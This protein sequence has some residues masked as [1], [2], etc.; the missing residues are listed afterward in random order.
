MIKQLKD[1]VSDELT[2]E[3]LSPKSIFLAV[4]LWRVGGGEIQVR[5]E[6]DLSVKNIEHAWLSLDGHQVDIDGSY[7]PIIELDTDDDS[8]VLGLTEST[9]LQL[10]RT[11]VEISDDEWEQEIKK[12]LL[13]VNACYIKEQ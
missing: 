12:A 13:I 11:M 5:I 1:S 9:A 10:V 7:P 6:D 8:L 3:Y 2:E 4:A